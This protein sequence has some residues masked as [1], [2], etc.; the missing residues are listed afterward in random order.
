MGNV[1]SR[2]FTRAWVSQFT[3]S[4]KELKVAEDEEEEDDEVEEDED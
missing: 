1:S 2:K 3:D 4:G